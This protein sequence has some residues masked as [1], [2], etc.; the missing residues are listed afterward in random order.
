[1]S[2]SSIVQRWHF[3][4]LRNERFLSEAIAFHIKNINLGIR[5]LCNC[6]GPNSFSNH[7]RECRIVE[8]RLIDG[9]YHSA[10]R[11]DSLDHRTE[12]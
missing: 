2:E 4:E 7:N 1:M 3:R 12:V 6:L 11:L 9:H 10:A 8:V 5:W